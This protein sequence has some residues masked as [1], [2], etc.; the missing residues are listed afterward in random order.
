[1][2]CPKQYTGLRIRV[3]GLE[4]EREGLTKLIMDASDGVITKVICYDPARIS[5]D[6]NSLSNFMADL[7]QFG[8]E[9]E[10]VKGQ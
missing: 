7:D 4:L 5:R 3:S 2:S 1:M 10:F 9:I 8:V 6:S